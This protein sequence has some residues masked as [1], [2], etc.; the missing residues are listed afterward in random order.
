VTFLAEEGIP[1]DWLQLPEGAAPD[2][3]HAV[4]AVTWRAGSLGRQLV[5][6]FLGRW[7]DERLTTGPDAEQ[8]AS[9]IGQ[10]MRQGWQVRESDSVLVAAEPVRGNPVAAPP[11]HTWRPHPLTEAEAR[12]QFLVRKP[13][14]AVFVSMKA[15]EVR[16]RKLAAL[17]GDLYGVDLMNKAFGPSGALTD[18]AAPKGDNA[19]RCLTAGREIAHQASLTCSPSGVPSALRN[20]SAVSTPR[21][22]SAVAARSTA[23]PLR[24][25]S[26]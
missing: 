19:R 6:R 13:E 17:G 24:I 16:V 10:L 12:P 3:V 15:A 26:G 25:A 21:S 1:P 5:R 11:M 2:D 23:S 9:L 8:R 18:R 22:W 14:Q 7:L 20:C 4:L